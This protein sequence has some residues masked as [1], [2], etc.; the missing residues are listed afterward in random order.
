MLNRLAYWLREARAHPPA[1]TAM[2]ARRVLLRGA[3]SLAGRIR[4]RHGCS[5]CSE[6]EGDAPVLLLGAVDR[7]G[8]EAQAD[9]LRS[10]AALYLRHEFDLLGSGWIPVDY[11]ACAAGLAGHLWNG[12]AHRWPLDRV[13]AAM[14]PKDRERALQ[15]RELLPDEYRPIDWHRDHRSGFRWNAIRPGRAIRYGD[16]AG[17]D[18]KWPWELGRMQHLPQLAIVAAGD[19]GPNGLSARCRAEIRNQIVDFYSMNPPGCGVQW[20]CTMDV[21][22]RAVNWLVAVDLVESCTGTFDPVFKALFGDAILDHAS[23][24]LENLE[25]NEA[26]RGNHFLCNLAGLVAI[27]G[28]LPKGPVSDLCLGYGY[29]MLIEE[30]L[31]QFHPNGANFEASTSYHRLSL[32]T[33]VFALSLAARAGSDRLG[34]LA[35][36]YSREAPA[37]PGW[38]GPDRLQQAALSGRVVP[39]E[40]EERLAAAFEMAEALVGPDG[41]TPLIGDN[42]N[43]RFLKLSPA[44]DL[45]SSPGEQPSERH[46]DHAHLADLRQAAAGEPRSENAPHPADGAVLAA[47]LVGRPLLRRRPSGKQI[48]TA[49]SWD[50][51]GYH[52]L[53]Q[54]RVWL[55]A[56]CGP[57]GQHGFGGHDHNDQLSFVLYIDGVPVVVDPGTFVYTPLPQERNAFRATAVHNTLRVEGCEQHA[58]AE[59][60]LFRLIGKAGAK[61]VEAGPDRIAM[62][63]EAF[64]APYRRSIRIEG[65]ALVVS[66]E[67]AGPGDG[68]IGL[69]LHPGRRLAP[70]PDGSVAISLCDAE[71]VLR[72]DGGDWEIGEGRYS[73]GYGLVE[74]CPRVELPMTSPRLEWRLEF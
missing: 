19:A 57:L 43:G 1:V 37:L 16:R 48:A 30:A 74:P 3:A 33:L 65:S 6:G 34:S 26:L 67:F 45:P 53:A 31:A 63:H 28:C 12:P 14:R 15:I 56:R 71:A 7:G 35:E 60:S 36:L 25:W 44:V 4:E 5:Y 13:L 42:D 73:P 66:E 18:V 47:L 61:L 49:R 72:T 21:A 24:I 50:P 39:V 2:R 70:R 58:F 55:L 68:R 52:L 59:D 27:G 38:P 17:A 46:D 69:T 23:H 8:L 51:P 64:G 41:R 54:D 62:A 10:V 32:E 20:A 9:R 40:L 22:I 29:T 11:G